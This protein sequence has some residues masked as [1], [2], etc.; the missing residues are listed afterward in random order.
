MNCRL[1][2]PVESI[3]RTGKCANLIEKKLHT[4]VA[5]ITDHML[6]D[7]ARETPA[8]AKIHAH[9]VD[10]EELAD[11]FHN[12]LFA[13]K[14]VTEAFGHVASADLRDGCRA[15][16][17]NSKSSFLQRIIAVLNSE[18]ARDLTQLSPG[19]ARNRLASAITFAHTFFVWRYHDASSE[20]DRWHLIIRRALAKGLRNALR[21]V[22]RPAHIA[23]SGT[24]ASVRSWNNSATRRRWP[25]CWQKAKIARCL[26][27]ESAT[28]KVARPSGLPGVRAHHA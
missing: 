22:R 17:E 8:G 14:I 9:R 4:P 11:D 6:F 5:G 16:F 25:R 1:D 10:R 2:E 23:I 18:Q 15:L 21:Q 20:P 13:A 19:L 27:R 7:I 24:P 26:A 28:K 3:S 12:I